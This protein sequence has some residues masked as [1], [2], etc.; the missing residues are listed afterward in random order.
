MENT[1]IEKF[2]TD[3][4]AEHRSIFTN[5]NTKITSINL[6]RELS[7]LGYRQDDIRN[8]IPCINTLSEAIQNLRRSEESI[9]HHPMFIRSDRIEI[10]PLFIPAKSDADLIN[11]WIIRTGISP[12]FMR[13][14]MM[15]AVDIDILR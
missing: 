15:N 13:T 14:Q 11:S 2:I 5:E 9:K 8:W 3:Q 7:K 4:M 10:N 6:I 12:Q 1:D